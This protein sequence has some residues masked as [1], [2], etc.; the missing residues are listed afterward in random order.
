MRGQFRAEKWGQVER[1]IQVAMLP[2]SNVARFTEILQNEFGVTVN[3]Y[4][5][6]IDSVGL[7]DTKSKRKSKIELPPKEEPSAS[8]SD[9]EL[10]ELE[11]EALELELELLSF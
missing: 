2:F 3:L 11:A 4:Q 9:T 6:Q 1:N 7:V 8:D 5:T 10:L